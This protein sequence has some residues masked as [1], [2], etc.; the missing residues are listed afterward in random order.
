L[1]KMFDETRDSTQDFRRPYPVGATMMNQVFFSLKT[2]V[3]IVILSNLE[4]TVFFGRDDSP[5]WHLLDSSKLCCEVRKEKDNPL[6]VTAPL[7]PAM[8]LGISANNREGDGMYRIRKKRLRKHRKNFSYCMRAGGWCYLEAEIY[9]Y[10]KNPKTELGS[11]V[12]STG[13]CTG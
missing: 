6:Q 5:F 7:V 3:M 11:A 10:W 9:G 13:A 12:R 2:R 4:G 8:Y 1:E